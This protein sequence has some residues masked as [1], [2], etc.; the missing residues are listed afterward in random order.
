M[1]DGTA[2][3]VGKE[4]NAHG[5][6][7]RRSSSKSTRKNFRESDSKVMLIHSDRPERGNEAFQQSV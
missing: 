2:S 3:C 4:D 6:L 1:L 7:D 5:L